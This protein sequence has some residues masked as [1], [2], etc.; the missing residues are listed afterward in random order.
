MT[1]ITL[2]TKL[3]FKQTSFDNEIELLKYLATLSNDYNDPEFQD[4]I[5]TPEIEKKLAQSKDEL[6]SNPNGFHRSIQ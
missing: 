2:N 5:I 6:K 4:S 3:K 1:T